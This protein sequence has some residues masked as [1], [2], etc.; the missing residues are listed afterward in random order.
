MN[1]AN[2][3]I[4]KEDFLKFREYFYRKTGI[5][6]DE[7]KRYFVDKR[8]AERIQ[9]TG[10]KNFREY[11]IKLRFDKSGIEFERLV[12]AMTVNET[13][14]FREEYQF[15]AMVNEILP[16][17]TKKKREGELIRIWSIPSSSGEEP[18]SIAIYLLEYWSDINNWD[19][20]IVASDIDTNMLEKAKEGKFSQ[21]SIQNIPPHLVKKY[22]TH[23]GNGQYQICKDLRDSVEFK[24]VNIVDPLQ[25]KAFRNFDLIF[26][27]NMLIYFDDVSRKIAAETLYDALSPGGFVLL[28]H[29]ESMS[30][31]TSIFK[32]RRFRKCIA[33]QK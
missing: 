20:E 31:V 18:Y 30:R 6:F 21:R 19:V 29:A 25:T 8:L 17:I 16:E 5:L 12:N 32:I 22:F 11:F 27:R 24:R 7:S 2:I 9:K 33:Y 1:N 10:C 14:F 13:Y 15:Q 3:N 28:G 23:N 4:T 26:C